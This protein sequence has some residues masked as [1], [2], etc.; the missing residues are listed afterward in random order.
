LILLVLGPGRFL[1][2]AAAQYPVLH[3]YAAQ[4]EARDRQLRQAARNGQQ[5]VTVNQIG[6]LDQTLGDLRAE[7]D[8]WINQKAADY[9]GLKSIMAK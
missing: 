1:I 9:Y 8:F 5:V 7:P 4:W 2:K 6:Q 3:S